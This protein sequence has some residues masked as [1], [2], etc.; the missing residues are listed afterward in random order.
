MTGSSRPAAATTLRSGP[1]ELVVPEGWEEQRTEDADALLVAPKP[2]RR[3][4]RANVVVTSRPSSGP[5]RAHLD[6]L[7][8]TAAAA[9]RVL[10]VEPFPRIGRGGRRIESVYLAEHTAVRVTTWATSADGR[11]IEVTL[12]RLLLPSAAVWEAVERIR[13]SLVVHGGADD[14]AE[15]PLPDL[16]TGPELAAPTSF[17]PISGDAWRLLWASAGHGFQPGP[18]R[19]PAGRELREAGLMTAFGGTTP[20]AERFLRIAKQAR[21]GTIRRS[22]VDGDAVRSVWSADGAAAVD[23]GRIEEEPPVVVSHALA[24]EPVGPAAV[25]LLDWMGVAPTAAWGGDADAEV[26]EDAVAARLRGST[27]PPDGAPPALL[28]AWRTGG[29][30]AFDVVV[31]GAPAVLRVLRAGDGTWWVQGP[32][33]DDGTTRLHALAGSGMID[34]VTGGGPTW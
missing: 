10:A 31:D 17:P 4:F 33:A 14:P 1:V 28:A 9:G 18:A 2:S 24:L 12:S 15:E 32:A 27:P 25:R 21:R 6:D 3:V 11:D 20:D 7:L 16:P 23:L 30:S 19:T 5:P 29:W 13:T 34:V 26:R 22:G 8:R